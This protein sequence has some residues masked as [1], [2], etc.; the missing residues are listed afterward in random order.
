MR[1]TTYVIIVSEVKF[2]CKDLLVL[3]TAIVT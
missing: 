3:M 1:L 2:L